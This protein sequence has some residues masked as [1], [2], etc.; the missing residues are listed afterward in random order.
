[1]RVALFGA[2]GFVG[3]YIIDALLAAG[4]LPVVMVRP[5]SE[6]KVRQSDHCITVPGDIGD[7]A[8][9]AATL[10]D[11]DAAIY[12]IGILRE[13]PA[14]GITFESMQFD[15]AKRCIDAAAERGVSRFLLMSANGVCADGTAYQRSK[16]KAEQY[17]AK[18]GLAWTVFRPSVLFGEPRG[19]MEFCTQLLEQMI[20][21]PIP[22]PAFFTGLL[23]GRGG[24][25][26]SPVQVEDVAQAF[27][28]SLTEPRCEGQVY[29]LG[30][31]ETLEWPEI[32]KRIAAAA[33]RRK[34]ILP[35]PA[36]A[37]RAACLL[38]DRY[39][40]FPMTRDQLT[41]LLEGNAVES[42]A[43]FETLK[44]RERAMTAAAL[45]YLTDGARQP[46]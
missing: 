9:V 12:L 19:R 43:A 11:C 33:G 6:H 24:F 45:S 46:L 2:T 40:W 35:A 25:A 26:M 3:S 44:I 23:P 13:D 31:A 41:M 32:I 1:M 27:V 36:F 5:G 38:L 29:P 17:L 39:A 7:G 4:H 34:L 14:A 42:R 18:S 15:G 20:E 16:F 8:A 10:R 22:A 37:V 28:R 21:P 30:G